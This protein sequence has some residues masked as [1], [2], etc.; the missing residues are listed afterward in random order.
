MYSEELLLRAWQL[1]PCW[2]TRH[3]G[4]VILL[5]DWLALEHNIIHSRCRNF[6]MYA[7]VF[8]KI[9]L[10]TNFDTFSLI[11]SSIM[12]SFESSPTIT[13][14]QVDYDPALIPS[15]WTVFSAGV[16]LKTLSSRFAFDSLFRSIQREARRCSLTK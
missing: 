3:F 8:V 4:S 6:D 5:I 12:D 2:N 7:I 1:H 14:I 13:F 16:F 9:T 10:F 11:F 15:S